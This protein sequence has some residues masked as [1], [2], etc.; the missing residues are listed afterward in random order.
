MWFSFKPV[1]V[2]SKPA[3]VYFRNPYLKISKDTFLKPVCGGL[4]VSKFFDRFRMLVFTEHAFG[5]RKSVFVF[6]KTRIRVLRKTHYDI[7]PTFL[8]PFRRN[9][10]FEKVHMR[11]FQNPHSGFKITTFRHNAGFVFKITGFVLMKCVF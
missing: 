8:Y 5:F 1:F 11:V 4:K 9:V 7:V 10:G 2:F 6:D 3:Y